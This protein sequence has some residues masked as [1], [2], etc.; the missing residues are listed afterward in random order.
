MAAYAA[1]FAV[2]PDG[3]ITATSPGIYILRILTPVPWRDGQSRA[4]GT[5]AT[6]PA[7]Q[8]TYEGPPAIS[9]QDV[10]SGSV[11]GGT[12]VTIT[13]TSLSDATVDFGANPATILSGVSTDS[14]IVVLSPE[15]SGDSPGTVD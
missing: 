12:L 2:N 1:S 4:Y 10:T 14:Q 8:F 7:D 13:G 9:S 5:S 3:S 11:Y 15:A 6:S